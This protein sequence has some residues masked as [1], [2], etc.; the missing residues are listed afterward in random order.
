MPLLQLVLLQ[1]V[2][3]L[4]ALSVLSMV[5]VLEEMV[6]GSMVE[7]VEDRFHCLEHSAVCVKVVCAA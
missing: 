2:Q 1:L 4:V 7:M 6:E 5:L 3:V